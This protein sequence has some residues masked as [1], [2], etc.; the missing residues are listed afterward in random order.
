[1]TENRLCLPLPCRSFAV[2]T[3]TFHSKLYDVCRWER[4]VRNKVLSS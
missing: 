3:R 1:M 4:V 2:I